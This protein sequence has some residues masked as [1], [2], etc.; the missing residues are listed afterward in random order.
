MLEDQIPM[1]QQ[2]QNDM[3]VNSVLAINWNVVLDWNEEKRYV[4]SGL[5]GKDMH[6]ALAGPNGVLT[7]IR[8]HW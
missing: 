1:A 4:V 5:K 6:A 3:K 7:W 2:L 8:Q